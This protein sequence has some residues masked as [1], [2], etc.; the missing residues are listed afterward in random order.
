MADVDAEIRPAP[1][2]A[3]ARRE[4]EGP[5]QGPA[6]PA[7]PPSGPAPAQQAVPPSG[8]APARP[9]AGRRSRKALRYGMFALGAAVLIVGGLWYYLS[10]GRYVST[11]DSYVQANVLT[12]STDVSGIVD[13]IPVHEGE[14]VA[15]G[16]VLFRLDPDKFQI[17]LDNARAN[18]AQTE[19]SL[20]SLKADY[21]RAQR[22]AAAEAALVQADQATFDRYAALVKERGVTEQQF[23]DAKFKLVADQATVGAG[24]AAVT[25]ALARLSGNAAMPIEQM[26]AYKQAAAQLAESQREFNHSIVRAPFNGIVTE[27][28]KLQPGQFL[29]VGTAAFG[30][31]A[32]DGMWVASEPKETALTFVRPG[33]S[34][35]VTIDAY[36]GH[37]WHGTVQSVAPASD[38]EFSVLPAQNSSGNWVKV[39]QRVPVRV[40]IHQGPNDPPLS[41]GMSAEASIDTH[42]HRTLADLF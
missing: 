14:H 13:Q 27:V 23:D 3:P 37:I 42:H 36:P 32:A 4:A 38:Q 26:P 10:G 35:T 2:A 22:Q 12:V 19:I 20:R 41:A 24:D 31:V 7:A 29:A 9:P 34:V 5:A 17:A 16:Q 30:L 8:Q 40:D 39:V 25:A 18:L 15:T 21:L 33:Q 1:P 11:D 28:S 6:R